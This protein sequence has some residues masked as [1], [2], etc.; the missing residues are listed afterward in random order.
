MK[1]NVS[2]SFP[3][4]LQLLLAFLF[5]FVVS[6]RNLQEPLCH[7]DIGKRSQQVP[8]EVSDHKVRRIMAIGVQLG[9]VQ[10]ISQ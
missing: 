2:P 7:E 1:H 5:F 6:A 4:V 9:I 3:F 8:L 10:W